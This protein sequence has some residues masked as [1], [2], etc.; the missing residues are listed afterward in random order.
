M[1]KINY[2][3]IYHRSLDSIIVQKDKNNKGVT[4]KKCKERLHHTYNIN[5]LYTNKP[6]NTSEGGVDN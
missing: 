4:R 5:K 2:N 6:I 1:S 3:D